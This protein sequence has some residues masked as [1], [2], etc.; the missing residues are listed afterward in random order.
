MQARSK[1]FLILT[2][3]LDARPGHPSPRTVKPRASENSVLTA[4]DVTI[5]SPSTRTN[6]NRGTT[7]ASRLE[8]DADD[9]MRSHL[10][11]LLTAVT[12]IM[13]STANGASPH[14]RIIASDGPFLRSRLIISARLLTRQRKWSLPIDKRCAGSAVGAERARFY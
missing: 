13:A 11:I 6:P 9:I 10:W 7:A 1:G 14:P 5:R 3:G 12:T 4:Y 2:P 8:N